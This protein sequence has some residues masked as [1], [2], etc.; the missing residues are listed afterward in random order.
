MI[1]RKLTV[2]QM[3]PALQAGGVERGTLEL[4]NYLVNQGTDL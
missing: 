3:L 2:V 4:G 1:K